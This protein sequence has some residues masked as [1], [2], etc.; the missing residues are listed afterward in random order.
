MF[1]A[2]IKFDFQVTLYSEFVCMILQENAE[3][4]QVL[5][6][7]LKSK[8]TKIMQGDLSNLYAKN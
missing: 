5:V 1:N 4:M 7:D 3:T 8:V 6:D 2:F